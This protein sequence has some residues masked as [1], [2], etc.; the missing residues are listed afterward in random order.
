MI[1]AETV[2]NVLESASIEE[3]KRFRIMYGKDNSEPKKR[4]GGMT[5]EEINEHLI[6]TLKLSK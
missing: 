6:R 3:Q 4:I 5:S 1:T 2:M